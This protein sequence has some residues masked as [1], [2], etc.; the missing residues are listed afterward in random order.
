MDKNDE[1]AIKDLYR[2]FTLIQS[3]GECEKFFS[4]LCTP[5]E[6]LEMA[7]RLKTAIMLSA[8]ANY[9]EINRETGC[10]TATISRVRRALEYGN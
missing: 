6:I 4:D 3:E 5:V 10:S 1:K 7:Q 8:G 9:A 2:A